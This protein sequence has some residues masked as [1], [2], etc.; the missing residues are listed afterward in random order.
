MKNMTRFIDSSYYSR[1]NR[2]KDVLYFKATEISS[3]LSAKKLPL[4]L[5]IFLDDSLHSVAI[6]VI[7]FYQR[8]LSPKKGY[9][10]AHRRLHGGDSC[11]EYVKKAL[12][13]K[14]LF[15]TTLLARQRFKE[16]NI[17]YTSL[18]D[19]AVKS[20]ALDVIS[21]DL[22]C[23]DPIAFIFSVVVLIL[24]LILGRNNGCCK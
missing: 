2:S 3:R 12:G 6:A 17:A 21:V 8:H 4:R 9:S 16:C 14:S 10:C 24:G 22:D 13:D 19:K 18:K 7:I 11:S 5:L 1:N 23:S 20:N 15:E